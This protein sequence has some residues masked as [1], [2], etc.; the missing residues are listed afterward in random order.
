MLSKINKKNRYSS[1]LLDWLGI[2]DK[3]YSI[4][5]IKEAIYNKCNL[6]DTKDKLSTVNL[7]KHGLILFEINSNPVKIDKI[8]NCISYKYFIKYYKPPY[9]H[10]DYCQKPSPVSHLELI[11]KN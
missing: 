1:E 5:D 11:I 10:Y 3:L 6:F 9:E 8:I 7:D 4:N 2:P